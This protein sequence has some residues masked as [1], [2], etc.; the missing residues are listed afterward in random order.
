MPECYKAGMPGQTKW[1]KI[2]K[3]IPVVLKENALPYVHHSLFKTKFD[4]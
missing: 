4:R 3:Y 1:M 2:I